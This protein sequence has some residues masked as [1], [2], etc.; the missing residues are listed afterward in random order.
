MVFR[1]AKTEMTFVIQ[2]VIRANFLWVYSETSTLMAVF[3][4]KKRYRTPD[5][6][7]QQQE[8]CSSQQAID[9][10]ADILQSSERRL[11]IQFRRSDEDVEIPSG[12]H[13]SMHID[14]D[15][16]HYG[17]LNVCGEKRGE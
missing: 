2:Q 1:R 11:C 16:A 3:P 4:Q 14:S 12:A 8:I 15:S 17:E 13:V 6:I 7:S 10:R 9:W 5:S